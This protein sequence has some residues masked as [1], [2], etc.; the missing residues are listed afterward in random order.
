LIATPDPKLTSRPLPPERS[1]PW[2]IASI[3]LILV[4]TGAAILWWRNSV[5]QS[6]GNMLDGQLTVLVRPPDRNIEPVGILEPGAVPVPH[7]GAMC[8]DARLKEPA[9]I[10]L[11]WID[12]AGQI[13]PL[14][15]WNNESLEVKDVD[16]PPPERRA[17]KL[18]FSP[19][20]GRNWTFG[21]T[22]GTET[23]LLLARRTPLPR[24]TQIGT[25]VKSLPAPP[26]L[27]DQKY[28]CTVSS[29]APGKPGVAHKAA[30]LSIK[31][32][33]LSNFI[34]P[35]G[36][37]FELVCAVQFAH[38]EDGKSGRTGEERLAK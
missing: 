2:W 10:Y 8:L 3:A 35:F 31:D 33:P 12:A 27:D 25:L 11:I 9:F 26:T 1:R 7:G 13:M 5:A 30:G 19:L 38:A 20:L 4:G 21:N 6:Q 18:V 34:A 23:L 29:R 14:Y 22:A 32:V 17:T 16:E 37:H 24:E 28:V 15:P 36:D